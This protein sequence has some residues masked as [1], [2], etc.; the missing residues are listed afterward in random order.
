[1]AVSK[2]LRYEILRRDSYTCRYCGASAPDV[3]LRVDHVTP[4]A[5]G[6]TDEP[7]N[8]AT[9]C[10]DCNAGKSSTNPDAPLVANVSDDALRWAAAMEQAAYNLREQETPKLEYRDAFLKEWHRWNLSKDDTKKVP[11]DDNWK[12]SVE[13]FRVAGVPVWMWADIVDVGMANKKVTPE[14]TFRYCCGIAWN[15][16]AALQAEAKEIVAAQI[17]SAAPVDAVVQ[18]AVA[19]WLRERG[20]E[21][22]S[23]D[24]EQFQTSAQLLVEHED[25]HRVV[26]AAQYAAW[27]GEADAAIAL[28]DADREQALQEWSLA[29]FTTT[30]EFPDD[31]RTKYVQAQID[32]LIKENTYAGRVASAAFYAGSRR[33]AY[34]HFGLGQKELE[35]IG[36]DGGFVKAIEAWAEAFHSCAGRWPEADE[37]SALVQS[38]GN[39]GED[40]DFWLADV[41]PAAAAAGAYQ[42][43]NIAPCLTRHLS[44]FDIAAQPLAGGMN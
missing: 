9:S 21:P 26:R 30:G 27:Y 23:A 3:P 12:Q 44:V 6:G 25:S 29:W 10:E 22:S 43:P 31:K 1:M 32:S 14:N 33:S 39:L 8:L 2:R 11:L 16:V 37:R 40:G 13:R 20:G 7:T 35:L 5:L 19:V 18:A 36:T 24:L 17:P 4:V 41:Y 34:L 15:K 42:D 28:R 38:M